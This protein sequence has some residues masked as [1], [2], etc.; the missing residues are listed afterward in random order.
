M[1][2]DEGTTW[3]S[4]REGSPEMSSTRS[5]AGVWLGAVSE[6]LRP[7]V[8]GGPGSFKSRGPAAFRAGVM[9]G[10]RSA[11]SPSEHADVAIRPR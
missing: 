9:N 1:A 8:P 5:G 11:S 7:A 4:V 3:T 2:A 6:R 10:V